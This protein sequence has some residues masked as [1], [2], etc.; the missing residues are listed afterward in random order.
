[1][2][3]R[4]Q[5]VSQAVDELGL[6]RKNRAAI[7]RLTASGSVGY[8]TE[9]ADGWMRARVRIVPDQMIWEPSILVLPHG[10]DAELDVVNDDAG[11]H[12]ALFPSNGDRQ[13]LPLPSYSRGT[14]R[15]NLDGPGLYWFSSAIGNDQGSGLRGVI[16]VL[17]DVPDH[18][19]LDRPDQPRP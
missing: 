17:G 6:D 5:D 13:F 3:T 15:I 8:A 2:T 11:T 14:A 4:L 9:D 1:M 16:L 12:A 18:A 7:G 19:R 10:G